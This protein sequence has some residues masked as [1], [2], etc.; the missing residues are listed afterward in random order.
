MNT[1]AVLLPVYKKDNPEFFKIAVNSLVAQT[2]QDFK[3]FLGVDGPIEGE[4]DEAVKGYEQN[5]AWA[6]RF[7]RAGQHH[8]GFT[9]QLHQS[10]LRFRRA[11]AINT[12]P[13]PGATQSGD[14]GH[15]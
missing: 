15:L 14:H 5:D 10:K 9:G 6:V 11:Q 4:L 3:I 12:L 2:L 8:Q 1:I 13:D 7:R